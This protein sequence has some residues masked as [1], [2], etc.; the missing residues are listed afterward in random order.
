MSHLGVGIKPTWERPAFIAFAI[1]FVL[2]GALVLDRSAFSERRRT[3]AGVFFRAGYAVREGLDPYTITDN[4]GWFYLYPPG[5][6]VFMVP[7]ADPVDKALPPCP[8]E[9]DR[10]ATPAA[11]LPYPWSVVAWYALSV[12]CLG[13]CVHTIARALQEGSPRPEIRLLAPTHGGWWNIRFW[14]LLM[15]MPD[16]G[17]TLSRGQV[18]ILVL[19]CVTSAALMFVRSRRAWGG[20]LLAFAACIKVFPGLLLFYPLAR[21]DWRG[22]WGY[23][24]CGIACMV[25]LPVLVF[26]PKLA[27]EHTWTFLSS[28]IFPGI[29][30]KPTLGAGTGFD[31]T[32]NLA[33]QGSLHNLLNIATPRGERPTQ[34]EAWIRVAHVVVS[35]GMLAATLLVGKVREQRSGLEIVLRL[36]MLCAVMILAVPMCHRHYYVFLFPCVAGLVFSHIGTS[37]LG[38]LHGWGWVVAPMY[39]ILLGVSRI[40]HEGLLRD[41]PIPLV[42]NLVVWGMSFAMLRK[43][44]RTDCP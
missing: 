23:V 33:I 5:M 3:D 17:S 27:I 41:L 39:P 21:R 31:N 44:A 13:I 36:G 24:A 38:T 8:P 10:A 18:N 2:F 19:A 37:R 7:L 30:G 32:D 12:A 9:L 34:P 16:F 25:V 14:P 20:F 28:M 4:N 26:G 22:M 43:L 6:A 35:L 11:Y 15:C 29:A 40:E 1:F 42:V